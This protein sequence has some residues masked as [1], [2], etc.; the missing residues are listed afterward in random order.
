MLH[1]PRAAG[2]ASGWVAPG[3]R[4][5]EWGRRYDS[6]REPPLLQPDWL[7]FRHARLD[8]QPPRCSGPLPPQLLFWLFKQLGVGAVLAVAGF[9]ARRPRRRARCVPRAAPIAGTNLGPRLGLRPR[10]ARRGEGVAVGYSRSVNCPSYNQI[11]AAWDEVRN[12]FGRVQKYLDLDYGTG[13]RKWNICSVAL[14]RPSA[15][16]NRV[17]IQR[18]VPACGNV[19]KEGSCM[20]DLVYKFHS[21]LVPEEVIVKAVQHFSSSD[22]RPTGQSNRTATFQGKPP[23]PWGLILLTIVGFALCVIPGIL[24]YI[25][26]IQRFYKF[27]NLVVTV[28][29]IAGGSEVI[30]SYPDF[31]SEPARLFPY[32]I[33]LLA[34]P[35]QPAIAGSASGELTG[36]AGSNPM[37][38]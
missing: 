10:V 3:C 35:T 20:P 9:G 26:L 19:S 16:A 38:S 6:P 24:C 23:L 37:E 7:G 18:L 33:P 30:V 11:A 27:H 14:V 8:P 12:T 32:T 17:S 31:A 21:A 13:G 29:P 34:D 36:E 5:F 25:F 22:W 4:A 1:R 15:L 28:N 2:R